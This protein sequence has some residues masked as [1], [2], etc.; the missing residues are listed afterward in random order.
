M[1]AGDGADGSSAASKLKVPSESRDWMKENLNEHESSQ[2]KV[3]QRDVLLDEDGLFKF[4]VLKSAPCSRRISA[5]SAYFCGTAN[6]N[7]NGADARYKSPA[8][9]ALKKH[10]I[11][12]IGSIRTTLMINKHASDFCLSVLRREMESSHH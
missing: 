4:R 5:T 3:I 2:R 9:A 8:R 11:D 1:M 12:Q 6:E 10:L 7:D